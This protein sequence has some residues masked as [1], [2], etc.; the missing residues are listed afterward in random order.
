MGNNNFENKN[1][2]QNDRTVPDSTTQKKKKNRLIRLLIKIV[3]WLIVIIVVIWL[4]LFLSSKIGE[5]DTIADMLRFIF[6]QF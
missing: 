4:T 1:D 5:F 3:I 2:I 6:A